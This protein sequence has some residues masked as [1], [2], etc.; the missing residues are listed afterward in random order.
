MNMA[1]SSYDLDE[2]KPMRGASLGAGAFSRLT[3]WLD[4]TPAALRCP[5]ERE[6]LATVMPELISLCA[7]HDEPDAIVERLDLIIARLPARH[8]LFSRLM[9]EPRRLASLVDLLAIAPRLAQQ[10]TASA[11]LAMCWIDR[12]PPV[13]SVRT[14]VAELWHCADGTG[15]TEDPAAAMK[16][17]AMRIMAYRFDLTVRALEGEDV[18]ALAKQ[19][20]RLADAALQIA[21]A[22]ATRRLR[23]QHGDLPGQELVILAMGRYGGCEL[24]TS[25]DLDLVFLFTGSHAGR[26]NGAR[27]LDAAEYFARLTGLVTRY[28]STAT[29]L[30][31]LYEVDT[32]LRPWGGKG[33]LACGMECFRQY[34]ADNAWTWEQMAL[35]RARIV[36]GSARGRKEFLHI[37][38]EYGVVAGRNVA[39]IGD[40]LAMRMTIAKNK[41]PCGPLD[42]KLVLGGLVDLEFAVHISQLRHQIG[43]HAQLGRAIRALSEA[44]V[45]DPALGG[46]HRLLS[47]LLIASRAIGV[48]PASMPTAGQQAV[49]ARACAAADWPELMARY[50]AA[51]LVVQRALRNT[52]SQ[53]GR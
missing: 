5:F 32:R 46:A 25:S 4:G 26:S 23:I 49:I 24:S 19:N 8:R 37:R 29:A 51:R 45:I 7:R 14:L 33:P 1:V 28:L 41:P 16:A 21:T 52:F 30:G 20:T 2:W 27:S 42:V 12:L 31:P 17:V 6:A 22:L 44:G 48:S 39:V 18:L 40:A 53:P 35:T 47:R 11:E 43:I 13:P 10:M 34:F 50:K 38:N 3:E 36:A 9:E 15:A